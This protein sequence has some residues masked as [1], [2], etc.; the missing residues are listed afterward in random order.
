M[1]KLLILIPLIFS[2]CNNTNTPVVNAETTKFSMNC[3]ND[4]VTNKNTDY[5]IYRC[6]N[7]EVICYMA[8]HDD[9]SLQCSFKE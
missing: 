1:K 9:A 8:H 7:D 5:N 3:T 4:L 2:G 6:E